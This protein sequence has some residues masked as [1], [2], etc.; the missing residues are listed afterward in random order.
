MVAVHGPEK[1]GMVLLMSEARVL[2][3]F[4]G[5]VEGDSSGMFAGAWTWVTADILAFW[6]ILETEMI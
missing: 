4:G 6:A 5:W 2:G 3:L 1:V